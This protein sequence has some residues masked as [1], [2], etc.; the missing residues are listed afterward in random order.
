[1]N[2][3]QVPAWLHEFQQLTENM[4]NQEHFLF[5]LMEMH[6]LYDSSVSVKCLIVC[7]CR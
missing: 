1:M 2:V 3:N 6:Q 4:L 7:V 5:L